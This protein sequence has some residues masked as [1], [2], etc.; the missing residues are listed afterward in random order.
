MKTNWKLIAT[1]LLFWMLYVVIWSIR[2]MAYAPTF[3][4]T[5]DANVIGAL[6]YGS[7]VY[8]NLYVFVPK[9]L[10][11][12]KRLLYGLVMI[13]WLLFMAYLGS[14]TFVFLYRNVSP[15]TSEFF[16]SAGG[17]A[18]T[19][20]EFMVVYAL[21]TSL[22]FINEW[23]IKERRL[24]ELESQNLKAELD[25]LKGQINPHFLFNA[26][27][28]VHVLIRTNP[29]LASNTLEKF[30]DL[31]SHQLYEVEKDKITLEQ[32]VQNLDNFI[33]LQKLRHQDHVQVNWDYSGVL[34][35]KPIAPMLFLNF[36]ENAFKHGESDLEAPVQIDISIEVNE[37]TLTFNCVNSAK[38]KADDKEKSGL[39]I[40]NIKRRLN[41]V[42]P[43]RHTLEIDFKDNLYRV[44]LA[45]NLNED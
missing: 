39:G 16:G 1:H 36:V 5:V 4:D 43:N 42:Y 40:D 19:A 9:L 25:M 15:S 18:S 13:V 35:D 17:L 14:Q 27:N 11:K 31:L 3:W 45:L 37:S 32:E 24:R 10:L 44:Q 21:A 38:K 6:L 12:G 2:D 33:Q 22:Y 26:L 23:Y 29:E 34:S 7:G 28:S 8:I 30:S 20:V 41:L